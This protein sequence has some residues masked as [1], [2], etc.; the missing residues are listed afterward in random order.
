MLVKM[1]KSIA[2]ATFGYGKGQVR[3]IDDKLARKW[4]KSGIAEP[5][6]KNYKPEKEKA[7]AGPKETRKDK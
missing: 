2:S 3:E 6:D 7:T 4:I 1:K 5:V